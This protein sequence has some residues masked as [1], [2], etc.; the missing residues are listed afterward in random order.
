MPPTGNLLLTIGSAQYVCESLNVQGLTGSAV[1]QF[2][3]AV[4]VI[5][6]E[7][8]CRLLSKCNR[9]IVNSIR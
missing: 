3:K 9:W 8:S 5:G 2:V 7:V 4:P 6:D 1:V